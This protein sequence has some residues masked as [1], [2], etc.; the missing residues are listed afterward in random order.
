M[1]RTSRASWQLKVEH[2]AMNYSHP[3]NEE[4]HFG[5]PFRTV[6][7]VVNDNDNKSNN[8]NKNNFN[9]LLA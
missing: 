1:V 5:F 9:Y 2:A 8:N 3:R 7:K 4:K 6:P